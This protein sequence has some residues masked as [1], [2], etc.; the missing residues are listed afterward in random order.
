MIQVFFELSCVI[1][2]TIIF[3]LPTYQ[4][5]VA[6]HELPADDDD[7]GNTYRLLRIPSQLP[8]YL[9]VAVEDNRDGVA[10]DANSQSM[11]LIIR[12][13]DAK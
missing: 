1:S 11:P 4:V 12:N 5:Q 8:R 13:V 7:A 3:I 10:L 6:V 2:I 9:P